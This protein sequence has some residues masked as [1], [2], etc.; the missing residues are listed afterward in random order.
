MKKRGLK[1]KMSSEIRENKSFSQILAEN[2]CWTCTKEDITNNQI[3]DLVAVYLQ[4]FLYPDPRK[5]EL[6]YWNNV[7]VKQI[8]K[9]LKK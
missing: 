9:D 7:T 5:E 2:I 3:P 8:I 6:E 1:Q 4:R